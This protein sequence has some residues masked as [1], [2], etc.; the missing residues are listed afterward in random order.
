MACSSDQ[1]RITTV[2]LSL[3]SVSYRSSLI[4][5]ANGQYSA[6][7]MYPG[8]MD[9]SNPLNSLIGADPNQFNLQQ[10]NAFMAQYPGLPS[11]TGGPG[12]WPAGAGADQ[13]GSQ[14]GMQMFQRMGNGL[15]NTNNMVFNPN[16]Q[17]GNIMG[18]MVK[19]RAAVK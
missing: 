18:P 10:M 9:G 2:R 1:V 17:Y 6:E 12:Y 14:Q 7:Y 13:S 16:M 19:F 8:M 11:L 15:D 4:V 5:D 3:S